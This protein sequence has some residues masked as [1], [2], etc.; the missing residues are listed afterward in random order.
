MRFTSVYAIVAL[1]SAL[2][3]PALGLNELLNR[4]ISIDVCGEVEAELK[5][6]N[7]F[8]KG[9][10]ITIGIIKECL[11]ISTLPQYVTSNL[12]ALGAVA[13]VGKATVIDQLT[14]MVNKCS[15]RQQ[16]RYPPH[17]VPSCKRGYPCFFTCK[18]GYSAY[19]VDKPTQCVCAAPYKECN[20]KC[21]TFKSC[22]SQI[23]KRDLKGQC[24]KGLTACGISGRG[25]NSWECVD[26]Q[27]DL[28]SCG[29]CPHSTHSGAYVPVGEDC[30]ALRGVSDVSCIKGQCV[31]HKCMPGYD[32]DGHHSE[33]VYSEDKD[34]QI[35]AAQYGLEHSQL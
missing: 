6:P 21:G 29:G 10:F 16:C 26:T 22:T 32:V 11:C 18:D 20:G 30:S 25:T 9:Q 3:S 28:E 2:V 7:L 14:D 12:L 13:L 24:P 31:V 5:I 4:D 23:P 15:G 27:T 34:P 19:P 8:K 33:C 17:S 1:V 35:L